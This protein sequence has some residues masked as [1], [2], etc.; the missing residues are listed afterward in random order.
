VVALNW[1]L[2]FEATLVAL[3]QIL[4]RTADQVHDKDSPFGELIYVSDL[5]EVRQCISNA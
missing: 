3:D 5:E 4:H 2:E 1:A